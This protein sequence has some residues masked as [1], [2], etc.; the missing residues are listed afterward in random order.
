[1]MGCS[2]CTCK[3]VEERKKGETHAHAQL[4]G[5]GEVR[6]WAYDMCVNGLSKSGPKPRRSVAFL[7]RLFL[8]PVF[9]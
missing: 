5:Y 3:S 6:R 7:Y 2:L 8:L 4:V 1:M 9:V